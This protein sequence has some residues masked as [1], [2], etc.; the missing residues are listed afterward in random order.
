M[1]F[2]SLVFE[3]EPLEWRQFPELVVLWLQNAGAV[4]AAGVFLV[5]LA[6]RLQR[7]GPRGGRWPGR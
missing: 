7:A 3:K 5:L 6:R 4:A 2:A 1:L